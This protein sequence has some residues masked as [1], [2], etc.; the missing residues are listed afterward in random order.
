MWQLCIIIQQFTKTIIYFFRTTLYSFPH[1]RQY[2]IFRGSLKS[3]LSIGVL[4]TANEEDR[5]VPLQVFSRAMPLDS[6]LTVSKTQ[7][8]LLAAAGIFARN[9]FSFQF[10]WSLQNDQYAVQRTLL[11]A[12]VRAA[13]KVYDHNVDGAIGGVSTISTEQE[14]HRIFGGRGRRWDWGVNNESAWKG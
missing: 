10:C 3:V 7:N 9:A 11:Q 1:L 8:C 4:K 2:C 13:G 5:R 14:R 12:A 6:S